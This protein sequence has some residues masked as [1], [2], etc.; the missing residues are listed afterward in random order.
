MTLV[1]NTVKEENKEIVV[2]ETPT[3][4]EILPINAIWELP[5]TYEWDDIP[6][7]PNPF[8]LLAQEGPFLRKPTA[9]GFGTILMDGMPR[10]LGKLGYE[11]GVFEHYAPRV[12]AELCSQIYDFFLR[13]WNKHRAEAEVI[14]TARVELDEDRLPRI[15][16]WRVFIPTQKVSGGGVE[17][18]Y[19]PSHIAKGYQVVGTV[20]SHCNFGAYHSST[21]TN[22]A[23]GMDGLHMTIGHVDSR[24]EVACMIAVNG[25]QV[26][27]DWKDVAD[28]SNLRAAT[29]PTW[30][31]NYVIPSKD[32][33]SEKAPVGM[34]NFDKFKATGYGNSGRSFYAW[35]DDGYYYKSSK[36][37]YKAGSTKTL[38]DLRAE[39]EK[40]ENKALLPADTQSLKEKDVQSTDSRQTDGDSEAMYEEWIRQNTKGYWEDGLSQEL[41]SLLFDN[42]LL[43]DSD[44]DLLADQKSEEAA[45]GQLRLIL[46]RKLRNTTDTLKLLGVEVDLSLKGSA[47]ITPIHNNSGRGKFRAPKPKKGPRLNGRRN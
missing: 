34:A 43:S 36:T 13:I 7:N 46:L 30:W 1:K 35:G 20:H 45:Q 11:K 27:Y 14:L 4:K 33:R 47:P 9:L 23:R 38:A 42:E 15:K 18:V 3:P 39:D 5:K 26:K 31:D 2:V 8:F 22:D 24:P 16:E 6:K 17:S 32:V 28:F 25:L 41:H 40:S 10:K 12:P 37:D 44:I 29:A 19:D 21:D